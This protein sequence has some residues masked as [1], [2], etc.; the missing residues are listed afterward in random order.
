[1]TT[2]AAPMAIP[3]F[4]G[5]VTAPGD[6]GYDDARELWNLMHDRRPALVARPQSPADVAAAIA[7]GREH[8]LR[9]AVRC[10]GHSLPGHSTVDGGLVIDLRSLN[11]VEVDPGSA[12]VQVGGGALLG[13]VDARV[14]AHG[15]VIP[16]GVVSHTGAG[17]LTLGGGV[18][19]MMRRYGLTVDAL[20]GA[21]VVLADGSIV[22]TDAQTR[23]DLFWG[24]RGGGG[25]FGIV[26]EFRFRAHPQGPL[27]VL[28]MFG[29]LTDTPA[30]LRLGEAMM[31]DTA[32]PDELLW[33]S[34]V[35]R[36]PD[37][38]P[39]MPTNLANTPGIMSLIEWSGDPA[40]GHERLEQ[41]RAVLDPPAWDLSEVPYLGM[42]TVTDA[43][44]APGTL[45]AYVKAGFAAE[46]T[47]TIIELL[48]ARGAEVGSPLSVIEVLSMGGAIDRVPA[49]DTAFPHR[50]ARWLINVPAQW[51]D[52]DPEVGAREVLWARETFAALE[53]H[54]S[55]GAYANFMEDD[56]RD[57]A[58]V[59]YGQTLVRLGQIKATYDPENVFSL[60]QNILPA[61]RT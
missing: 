46:L 15:L 32:T 57:A 21:E 49:D 53:P 56:E 16:V 54:L 4:T 36:G 58:T 8:G 34:F 55:G 28:A 5:P 44:L 19:R 48:M 9:I 26:T 59:A 3:G 52:P 47:E 38:A 37:F 31:A 14:Q 30:V 22:W 20:L 29:P 39:W 25:N 27:T 60:N 17:G 10:G 13:D 45:R 24:L 51:S 40:E 18:G 33:T 7:H 1:M 11:K 12:T 23:P 6:P 41:I 43:L 61:A 35:R 50:G 42:Q 2:D